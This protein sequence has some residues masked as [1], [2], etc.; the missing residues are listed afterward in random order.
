LKSKISNSKK[1]KSKISN[2]K[3]IEI[4]NFQLQKIEIENFQLQ[5]IEIENFQLQKIE[6]ENLICLTFSAPLVSF[7]SY[8][9]W[10]RSQASPREG[11][12]D[13]GPPNLTLNET[14]TYK[15]TKIH[16]L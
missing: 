5:K 7:P 16:F 9:P 10:K 15:F 12:A 13:R 8:V 6:I 4:E 14:W 3:K 1:L 11:G 2:S